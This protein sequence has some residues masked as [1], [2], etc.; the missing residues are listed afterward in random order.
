MLANTDHAIIRAA[1]T[2]VA[3]ICVLELPLG[4]WNGVLDLLQN[5]AN[6]DDLNVRLASIQTLGFICE[7]IDPKFLSADQLNMILPAVLM[8]VIPDQILL[9]QIAMKA[10]ARAAPITEQ[11]FLVPEQKDFIM[12]KIF[13]ASKINDED[14][15]SSVME[16]LNDIVRVNYD[17]MN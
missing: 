3:A 7:D 4:M 6:S 13:D 17:Y 5:N 12:Q 11:N 9:T 10:F 16:G 15:L 14:V 1:A 2:C 8:N